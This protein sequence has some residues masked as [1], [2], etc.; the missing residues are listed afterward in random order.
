MD[1]I[2][3]FIQAIAVLFVGGAAIYGTQAQFFVNLKASM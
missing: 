1:K 3:E 2:K